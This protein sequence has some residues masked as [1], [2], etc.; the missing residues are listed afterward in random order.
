[1]R[2]EPLLAENM[3]LCVSSAGEVDA[4]YEDDDKA[5]SIDLSG[6]AQKILFVE[7]RN[8]SVVASE[9]AKTVSTELNFSKVVVSKRNMS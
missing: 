4:E 7:L 8:K 5:E 3:K 6:Y 2:K 9:K 1:M